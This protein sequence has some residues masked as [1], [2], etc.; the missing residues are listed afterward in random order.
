[1]IRLL[2]AG[3]VLAILIVGGYLATTRI[4]PDR[5]Q[6]GTVH[7]MVL[8]GQVKNADVSLYT[9]DNPKTPIATKQ[10]NNN[11]LFSLQLTEIADQPLVM[12]ATLDERVLSAIIYYRAGQQHAINIT[13]FTHLGTA[14]AS[15]HIAQQMAPEQAITAAYG[16]IAEYIGLRSSDFVGF[17]ATAVSSEPDNRSNSANTYA[18]VLAAITHVIDTMSRSTDSVTNM[19]RFAEVAFD[20]LRYDSMING[21]GSKGHLRYANQYID[22]NAFKEKVTEAIRKIDKSYN[23]EIA[24]TTFK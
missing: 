10:L 21:I 13:L 22:V 17:I 16:Q 11:G 5:A 12:V 2:V 19:F 18:I 14:L 4:H 15:N 24:T 6:P 3:M 20:D 8:N 23:R 7:G 9:I 1:M